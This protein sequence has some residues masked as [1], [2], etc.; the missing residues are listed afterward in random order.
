MTYTYGCKYDKVKELPNVSLSLYSYLIDNETALHEVINRTKVYCDFNLNYN[1]FIVFFK[2]LCKCTISTKLRDFQYHLLVHGLVTNIQLFYWKIRSD[3][4]CS[5][6]NRSSETIEH[7][8][9][10]C[11][12]SQSFNCQ[13]ENHAKDNM[14]LD[15]ALDTSNFCV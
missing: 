5:F 14:L 1:T 3:K 13:V 15:D 7:L 12:I 6:S 2:N 11:N 4:L 9:C 8:S 10:N